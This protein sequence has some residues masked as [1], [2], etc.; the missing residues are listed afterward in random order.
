MCIRDRWGLL[1]HVCSARSIWRVRRGV[2]VGSGSVYTR[3]LCI[4]GG[5]IGGTRC[6][7][8]GFGPPV[9]QG[10]SLGSGCVGGYTFDRASIE[11]AVLGQGV[12]LLR[13]ARRGVRICL[14]FW[15]VWAWCV[16]EPA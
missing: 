15:F 2:V 10:V 11:G 1:S 4:V 7:S 9:A 5:S 16:W 3:M 13:R 8:R 6:R 14:S 12:L